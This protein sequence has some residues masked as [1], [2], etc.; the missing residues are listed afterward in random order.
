MA[1]TDID[2]DIDYY[3][4]SHQDSVYSDCGIAKDSVF[5]FSDSNDIKGST[6]SDGLPKSVDI[7]AS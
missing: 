2:I 6:C 4:S 7:C 1:S 5:L 3:V